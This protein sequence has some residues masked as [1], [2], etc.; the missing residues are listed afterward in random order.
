M[1]KLGYKMFSGKDSPDGNILI[2][3]PSCD[4]IFHLNFGKKK[5]VKN[6][7]IS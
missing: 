1:Q 3:H 5:L 7:Y 4:L 6:T 2:S